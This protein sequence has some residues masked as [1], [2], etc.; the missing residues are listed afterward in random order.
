M[1]GSKAWL[2]NQEVRFPLLNRLVLGTPLGDL[3]FPEFQ[4]AFFADVGRAWVRDNS[5]RGVLGSARGSVRLAL[6]P[7]AVVRLDAG[8]RFGGNDLL[9]YGLDD[10]QRDGGFVS[11]FFGYNY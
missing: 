9:G 1:I 7:L 2:I 3:T 5:T 11:V 10:S 4:G 8:V 6:A